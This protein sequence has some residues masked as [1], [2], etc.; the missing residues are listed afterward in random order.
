MIHNITFFNKIKEPTTTREPDYYVYTDGSCIHNGKPNAKAGYGI[1]FGEND[2]RNVS[3]RIEEGGKQTN[4]IAE[5]TA[6]VE[7]YKIIQEDLKKGKT[8]GIVSDSVYSLRCITSY[9]E[10]CNKNDW[11]EDIPNKELVKYAYQLF[12][13]EKNIEFIHIKAHTNK[14]DNHSLG[15]EKADLLANQSLGIVDKKI[16]KNIYLDVPYE[17][18]EE[19]KML[20][21]KWDV[22]KKK[23]YITSDNEN[24]RKI[25]ELFP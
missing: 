19:A 17:R 11:K 4:N 9:G 6:I 25:S 24:K 1:Y 5:L 8:V 21:A 23:W 2:E 22:S 18:K 12:K 16:V 15:N 10:K 3:K 20:G 7:A 13:E 14:T